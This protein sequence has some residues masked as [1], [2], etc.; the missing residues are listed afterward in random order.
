[1]ASDEDD[2]FI[3]FAIREGDDLPSRAS[4]H[5]LA[6]AILKKQ[7]KPDEASKPLW[8]LRSGGHYD[9][10]DFTV[11]LHHEIIDFC[12]FMK[13][14]E[15]ETKLRNHL[16]ERVKAISRDTFPDGTVTLFG[17]FQYDLSLPTSD[18]DF[19]IELPG[20]FRPYHL[21]ELA[22]RFAD[23]DWVSKLETVESA[24]V[25]IVKFVDRPSNISVDICFNNPTATNAAALVQARLNELPPLKHLVLV[26]KHFLYCR[27]MNE[28]F[29]GGLGSFVTLMMVSNFLKLF[30]Q[31]FP[32]RSEKSSVKLLHDC[33]LGILL[34]SFFQLYGT[35][36]NF[37]TCGIREAKSRYVRKVR[38]QFGYTTGLRQ[39]EPF[40]LC[41][42]SPYD[43]SLDIGTSSYNVM[44]ARAAF[45]WAYKE[46]TY[47]DTN[48][49]ATT[50]L[51]RILPAESVEYRRNSLPELASMPVVDDSSFDRKD[52]NNSRSSSSKNPQKRKRHLKTMSL[53]LK[54][55]S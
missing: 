3:P 20:A 7:P 31:Q 49:G 50:L 11:S 40:L 53:H 29:Y 35:D 46:L 10:D 18:L 21:R 34:I 17:S 51:S 9:C 16:I 44:K 1:M 54:Q 15:A 43:R 5:P 26:I 8:A 30:P 42:E 13:P 24:R 32:N 28:T 4:V 47:E 6:S 38:R 33:N 25:P 12:T 52:R 2:D 55:G 37:A 27:Q 41:L 45:E 39:R 22:A 48:T 14:T 19:V 36:F 23:F